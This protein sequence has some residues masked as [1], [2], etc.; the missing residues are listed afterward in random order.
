VRRRET[1]GIRNYGGNAVR[2]G[3]GFTIAA[4]LA[5]SAVTLPGQT[6]DREAP[7]M[8]FERIRARMTDHLAHMPNYTC[9]ESIERMMMTR[10]RWQY[11]DSVDLEVAF[12]D[13]QELFSRPGENKF[14]QEPIEK[15]VSGGTIGNSAL[16]SH[17]DVILSRNLAEF[18]YAGTAK[19]DGHRTYRYDLLV[20]I[21]KSR[22]RV[23]HNGEEGMAGYEG[24]VWVDADTLEPVRVDFKVNRIPP[25]LGVRLIEESLHYKTLTIGNS[26]YS[27]PDRSELAALDDTGNYSLNAIKLSACREFGANSVVTY[28]AP[29]QGTPSQGTASREAKEH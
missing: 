2:I 5:L 18:H 1:G 9:H 12:V 21:E 4:A 6:R 7:E 28:G 16:G 20:P 19:K 25:R 29:T 15:M 8:L 10:G 26:E 3:T 13:D 24:T 17:L 14:G 23:R 11:V 22:F 27:L